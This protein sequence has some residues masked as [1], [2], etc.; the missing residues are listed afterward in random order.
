MSFGTVEKEI[1][2]TNDPTIV[3]I[4]QK[5]YPEEEQMPLAKYFY[6]YPLHYPTPVEMQLIQK[7]IKWTSDQWPYLE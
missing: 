2:A 3:N 5:L 7:P 1:I 6:S 4:R